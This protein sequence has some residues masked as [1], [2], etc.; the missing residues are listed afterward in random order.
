ML[1]AAL[2]VTANLFLPS[3]YDRRAADWRNGPIVYQIF[4]DRFARS[5]LPFQLPHG[6]AMMKWDDLPVPGHLD[7][8][9]GV[10]SHELQ[11]WGGDLVGARAR[12]GYIRSLHADAVYLTPIFKAL[13]NH[14][15]DTQDYLQ[16][17]PELGGHEALELFIKEAHNKEMRVILDGVFNHVGRTSAIFKAAEYPKS[18]WRDAFTFDPS[19]PYGYRAWANVK[20]LPAWN[21]DSQ[22]AKNYLWSGE[23]SVVKRY[24]REGVDG[25]RLD[26]A[27]DLGPQILHE[28][29]DTAHRTKPGSVVVGEISGYPAGWDKSVDGVFNFF[30]LKVAHSL[31][32]GD[33]D[34]PTVTS[35]LEDMVKDAG[36]DHL[37]QSWL[38]L[39][40]H[41]TDR[42]ASLEPD[43]TRRR[44]LEFLQFTLPGSPLIYYGSELGMTGV[45]DPGNRAPMRWDLAE[46][47]NQERNW[48]TTLAQHRIKHRALRVGD[49]RFL[50]SKNLLA[51][52]RYT[53]QM[54]DLV[55]VIVNPLDRPVTESIACRSGSIMSW[56]EVHDGIGGG[57][58]K[59]VNGLVEVQVAPHGAMLLTPQEQVKGYSPTARIP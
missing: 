44:L 26:V 34:G 45:G 31:L 25:W 9:K 35:Q 36:I 38:L 40:N 43:F 48:I 46:K 29:T 27:Y 33:T 49:V 19:L 2:A 7:E 13:T 1:S 14:R 41:D 50:R 51:F 20:N 54:R 6:G 59:V 55:I 37:L 39:D 15:Y 18:N 17:A 16:V 52:S 53:D 58:Y 10:Y 28:I 56:G 21:L 24:L 42:L 11:F 32:L 12:L 57:D 3:V 23:N 4:V 47:P 5:N 22:K 30:A 8:Q